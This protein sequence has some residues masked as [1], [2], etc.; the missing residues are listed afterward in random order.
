[1]KNEAYYLS[2][3]PLTMA[4][5]KAACMLPGMAGG[6]GGPKD[7][8]NPNEFTDSSGTVW[9]SRSYNVAHEK[10][11]AERQGQTPSSGASWGG[12]KTKE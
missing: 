3:Y 9:T 10:A 7:E 11:L 8:D 5:H 6:N 12:T 2:E 4:A 1:M